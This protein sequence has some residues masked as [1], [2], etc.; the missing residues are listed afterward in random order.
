MNQFIAKHREAMFVKKRKRYYFRRRRTRMV[1][2]FHRGSAFMQEI[3]YGMIEFD[4]GT[5]F[6]F[7]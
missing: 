7:L 1:L 3:R 4:A 6:L 5:L 2:K